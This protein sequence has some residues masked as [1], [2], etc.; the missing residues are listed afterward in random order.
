VEIFLS[1]LIVVERWRVGALLLM[2]GQKHRWKSC[3]YAMPFIYFP[4][5]LC[6]RRSLHMCE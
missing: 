4:K 6:V 1:F 5:F 3:L 2:Q